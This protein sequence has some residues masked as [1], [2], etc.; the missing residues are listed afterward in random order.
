MK[1]YGFTLSELLVAMAIIGIAAA[2]AAPAITKMMPDRNKSKVLKYYTTINNIT[3]DLLSNENIY[4]R[5]YDGTPTFDGNGNLTGQYGCNGLRCTLQPNTQFSD[6]TYQGNC[7]YPK[8]M[9]Y[10]LNLSPEPTRNT[11][12]ANSVTGTAQDNSSWTIKSSK[13]SRTFSGYSLRFFK[14][15]LYCSSLNVF[16]GSFSPSIAP[17]KSGVSSFEFLPRP[18]PVFPPKTGPVFLSSIDST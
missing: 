4:Y 17:E 11:C 2:I 14:N 6:G 1:K 3:T 15:C 18:R 16:G 7:K 5:R 9:Y 8:L 13:A 12:L 10:Y